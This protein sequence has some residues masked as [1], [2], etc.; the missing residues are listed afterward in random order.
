[1][2]TE[3][4]EV[5]SA[6][7]DTVQHET[8]LPILDV[9]R[10]RW[11]PKAFSGRSVEPE[12]LRTVLEAARWA[13]SSHNEQPWSFVLV[14]KENLEVYNALLSCLNETNRQWA[15]YAPVLVLSVA[16]MYYGK[17]GRTNR[18]AFHD[19]GL[20]TANLILQATALELYT[21]PMA[22]FSV[23]RAREVLGIPDGY[24]PVAMI[25]LGYLPE[26]R[27]LDDPRAE[28]I[29]KNRSRK[30]FDE[31]VFEGRWSN[32]ARFIDRRESQEAKSVQ[33]ETFIN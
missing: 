15:Q 8:S 31:F 14:T 26:S 29:P 1:M 27:D 32:P 25:A 7:V 5:E 12:N 3:S 10:R 33:H 22:G 21:R 19:V 24:E 11:S 16:K 2:M 13:P 18:H 6:V 23:Q 4:I 9:L 28:P 17:D 20:A 30:E